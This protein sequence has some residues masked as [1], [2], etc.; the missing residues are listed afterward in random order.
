ME[1]LAIYLLGGLITI[2]GVLWI[3]AWA[4]GQTEDD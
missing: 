1:H 4:A 3:F 2:M